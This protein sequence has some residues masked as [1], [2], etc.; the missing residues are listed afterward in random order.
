MLYYFLFLFDFLIIG[1]F[2]LII[3][4]NPDIKMLDC[5]HEEFY[6]LK[7]IFNL[8]V[9]DHEKKGTIDM[10]AK[11]FNNNPVDYYH[12]YNSVKNNIKHID[13]LLDIKRELIRTK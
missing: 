8:I 3:K 10:L 7:Y 5:L 12:Y 1:V 9:S 2:K 13:K 11:E 6:D 4:N